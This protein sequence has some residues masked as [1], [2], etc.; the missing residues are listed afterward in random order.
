VRLRAPSGVRARVPGERVLSWMVSG[1]S[2]LVATPAALVLPEGE[3]ESLRV[4]WDL[5]LRTVWEPDAVEIT[6]Q[7]SA[8]GRPVVHRVHIGGDP[9]VL[10]E[11]V[12]EHVTASIV[13]QHHVELVGERGARFVAR[14]I[15][16]S[17]DLRWAIVFDAGL[18]PGDPELR[19]AADESLT[20]LRISLGI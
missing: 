19:R 8:G 7:E 17:T 15:P 2:Y 4:P 12:R 20:A 14:R 5:V 18:D 16:G 3:H 11:V 10:P 1:S 13:V 9:G 6:A